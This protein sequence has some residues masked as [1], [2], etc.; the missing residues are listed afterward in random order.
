MLLRTWDAESAEAQVQIIEHEEEA[1]QFHMQVMQMEETLRK[2]METMLQ[3]K[4]DDQ[5]AF[6]SAKE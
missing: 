1:E 4:V 2:E 6:G 3:K 5:V